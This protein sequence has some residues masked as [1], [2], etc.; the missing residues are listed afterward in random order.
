MV[1]RQLIIFGIGSSSR[2]E[3]MIDQVNQDLGLRIR[4]QIE[5][6]GPSDHQP[7][8]ERRVPVL[9]LFTGL[10]SD[11]HRPSDDFE[12]INTEGMVWITDIVYRLGDDLAK[13]QERP[14]YIAVQGRANIQIGIESHTSSEP[15]ESNRNKIP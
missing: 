4:K 5:A 6:M 12:R 3:G 2:F 14:D 11:Y 10:H 9:H 8:F 1:D 15:E 13:R 7:F